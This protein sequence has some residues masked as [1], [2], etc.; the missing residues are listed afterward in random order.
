MKRYLKPPEGAGQLPAYRKVPCL[1]SS[2]VNRLLC[3]PQV[4]RIR[5]ARRARPELRSFEVGLGPHVSS[6]TICQQL[7]SN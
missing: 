2:G 7:P 6:A 5:V 4:P 3:L 1:V